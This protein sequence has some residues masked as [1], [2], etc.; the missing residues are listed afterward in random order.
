M[1]TFANLVKFFYEIIFLWL[2]LHLIKYKFYINLWQYFL[3]ILPQN[4]KI[5]LLKQDLHFHET[6]SKI[7]ACQRVPWHI[8]QMPNACPKAFYDYR[9]II[10]TQFRPV[11]PPHH[12]QTIP[13]LLCLLLPHPTPTPPHSLRPA[14][15]SDTIDIDWN[16]SCGNIEI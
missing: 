13:A 10:K 2:T 4:V 5:I 11:T 12:R 9:H 3:R 7:F 6:C 15:L 8:Q 16:L 1:D 14:P